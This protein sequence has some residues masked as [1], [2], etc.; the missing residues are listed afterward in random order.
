MI[1][2]VEK[3]NELAVHGIFDSM[4]RAE[5]HLK[6]TIPVYV[7]RGYYMDETLTKDSF[8]IINTNKK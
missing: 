6:E 1:K 2:I 4:E 3:N 7:E 8:K 5:K